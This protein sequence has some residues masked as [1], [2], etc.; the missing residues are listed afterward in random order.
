MN[1]WA[2][3]YEG[4]LPERGVR[5]ASGPGSPRSADDL[6]QAC[7][8][9]CL[10]LALG[11]LTSQ[12]LQG[13]NAV[14]KRG[15]PPSQRLVDLVSSTIVLAE[16][17]SMPNVSEQGR[18]YLFRMLHCGAGQV[19]H[20][21]L[22]PRS[23]THEVVVTCRVCNTHE[24]CVLI[25]N[26]TGA[27]RPVRKMSQG[28]EKL[29]RDLNT[30]E[31]AGQHR[32]FLPELKPWIRLPTPAANCSVD[33]LICDG[34]PS[35]DQEAIRRGLCVF[36]DGAQHRPWIARN[37]RQ[38]ESDQA[39]SIQAAQNGYN[40]LRISF[41]DAHIKMQVLDAAWRARSAGGWVRVSPSWNQGMLTCHS[42]AKP[43]VPVMNFKNIAPPNALTAALY[44]ILNLVLRGSSLSRV[45][46]L[47][48]TGA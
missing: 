24:E 12:S 22:M 42:S 40:V 43:V 10:C 14:R 35:S 11:L 5:E 44:L 20:R 39:T 27:R 26:E 48:S 37:Q 3:C 4:A 25:A 19:H 46:G 9:L 33:V 28:E 38:R 41:K 23:V 18:Q 34:P 7:L 16:G 1:G 2:I 32:A 47:A 29:L 31:V 30:L 17:D 6:F 21:V 45:M 13:D 8:V 15:R 36:W